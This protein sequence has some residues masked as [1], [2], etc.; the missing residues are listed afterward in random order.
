MNV[1]WG[2][3]L[4]LVL[5][6]VYVGQQSA[7]HP[8]PKHQDVT[9]QEQHS[10]AAALRIRSYPALTSLPDT[11]AEVQSESGSGRLRARLNLHPAPK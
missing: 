3:S 2:L 5:A 10:H 4:Q 11:S 8:N 9:T 7:E 1:V 6:L